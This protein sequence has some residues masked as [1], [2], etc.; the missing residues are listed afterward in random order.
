ML[1]EL[2]IARLKALIEYIEGPEIRLQHVLKAVD[3]TR[4]EIGDILRPRC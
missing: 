3:A 2:V 1:K 4:N